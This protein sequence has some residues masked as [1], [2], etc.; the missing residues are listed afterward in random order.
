MTVPPLA[1]VSVPVVFVRA[2]GPEPVVDTLKV[3]PFVSVTNT[4]PEP[5]APFDLIVVVRYLHRPL[6]PWIERSLAPGGILLYET[7]REGQQRFGPPRRARHL[8]RPGELTTTFPS[9]VVEHHEETEA[10][11]PPLLARLVARKPH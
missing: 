4:P 10:N 9:L 7:F 8:L 11:A 2:I 1:M 3:P 5:A 6:F